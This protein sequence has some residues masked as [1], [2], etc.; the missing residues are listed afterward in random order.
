MTLKLD[1][2][3]SDEFFFFI[4]YGLFLFFTVLSTSLYYQVFHG[5]PFQVMYVACVAIL[6]LQELQYVR[7]SRKELVGCVIAVILFGIPFLVAEGALQRSVSCIFLFAFCARRIPFRKIARFTLVFTGILVLYVIF[8]SYIGIIENYTAVQKNRVREYLGFRYALFPSAHLL[9]LISLWIY[10]N[11]KRIPIPGALAW[12]AAAWWLYLKTDS[13]LSFT[14]S[15]C[16]LL[17]AVVLRFAPRILDRLRLLRGLMV[18]S[19]LICGGLSVYLTVIYD[20]TVPWMAKLNSML[21]D[22]LSLGQNSL[23]KY[24][25]R[26]FGQTL[27]WVGNGLDAFGQPSVGTYDYVDCLYVKI[28]QNYGPFF[29]LVFLVLL[30]VA[31]IRC[32]KRRDYHLLIIMTTVAGHCMLDD[33]SMYLYYNTFWIAMGALLLN[34]ASLYPTEKEASL[35]DEKRS[36][37]SKRKRRRSRLCLRWV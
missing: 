5:R 18:G 2:Y 12:G 6:L 14:I 30:T 13:R 20:K 8:S 27:E 21:S 9:N 1:K 3:R 34:P 31:L 16:L 24:G 33:L 23:K 7:D 35:R 11:K 19:F 28:L 22:R 15:L 26:P 4:A 32:N 17:A 36:E 29:V 25:V 37:I 10:L